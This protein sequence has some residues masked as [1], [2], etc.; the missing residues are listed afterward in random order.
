MVR[1]QDSAS[2]YRNLHAQWAEPSIA[3]AAD[4]LKRL[5]DPMRR[6]VIGEAARRHMNEFLSLPRFRAAIGDALGSVPHEMATADFS[7]NPVLRDG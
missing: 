3:S 6:N 5:E 7:V 4:W 2:A 1:M